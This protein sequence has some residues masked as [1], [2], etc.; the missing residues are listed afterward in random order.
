ME[1]SLP[2]NILTCPQCGG[3][4]I[5]DHGQIFLACPYCYSTVYLDKSQ[6]VFHW[7]LSPT[8]QETQAQGAL[9]RWMAG[10]QT[11]K[12]LDKKSQVVGSSFE[13]FPLWY[14]KK[15]DSKG[16]EQIYL[17]PAAAT[18]VSELRSLQLTAGDLIKYDETIAAQA[19]PPN[20]P[21]STAL[22]WLREQHGVGEAEIQERALVHIPVFTF[23]YIYQGNPYTAIVEAGTGGVFA[24]IYPAKAEAPYLMAGGVT[25]LVFL[26]LATF[27]LVGLLSAGAGGA[28]IGL[29]LCTGLGVLAAP[30]L[31]ALAV[32]VAAKV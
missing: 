14:F 4:L 3:E 23:K 17:E 5:A 30:L 15:S 25:A 11:V 9:A 18:S 21:L 8:M 24:N 6:V 26:C 12:D 22:D 7:Y 1:A 19:H 31:F 29:L 2:E 16:N 10:N 27:P 32:W 28:S 13:Y 20:V